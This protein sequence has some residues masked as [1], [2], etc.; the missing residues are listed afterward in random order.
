MPLSAGTR[1]GHY[2]VTPLLGEGAWA[3]ISVIDEP[4]L[5]ATVDALHHAFFTDPDGA[6]S[7]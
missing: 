3:R 2:D 7:G 1:L 6:V 5:R 4:D